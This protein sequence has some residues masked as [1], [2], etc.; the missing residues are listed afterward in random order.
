[1]TDAIKKYLNDD[2]KLVCLIKPEFESAGI[3]KKGV[4]KDN[5]TH[6]LILN[7][8]YKELVKAGLFINQLDYSPI[9]GGSGNIE[10]ISIIETK[11]KNQIDIDSVVKKA[12]MME[13]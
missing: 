11:Y 7:N 1:L 4:I 9:K 3:N 10:F 12:H 2:N 13:G 6:I 5:K 8:V